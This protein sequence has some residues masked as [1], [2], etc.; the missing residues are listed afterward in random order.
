[1]SLQE[2]DA[3]E[4]ERLWVDEAKRRLQEL[5]DGKVKAIPGDE[6]IRRGRAALDNEVG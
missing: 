3:I 1:M 2:E 6:A 4:I 5:I